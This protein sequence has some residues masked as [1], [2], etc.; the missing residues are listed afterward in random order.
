MVPHLTRRV[1]L[2]ALLCIMLLATLATASS[3]LKTTTGKVVSGTITGI[4]SSL[5]LDCSRHRHLDI[6]LS[7]V[8][9]IVVDFPR[10]IVETPTRVYIGPYSLFSGINEVIAIRNGQTNEEIPFASLRAIAPNG[11]AFH[12]L[13]R[14]WLEDGFVEY[15]AVLDIEPL[16]TRE[17]SSTTITSPERTYS[18]QTWEELYQPTPIPEEEEETPWWLL[19]LI[20]VGLGALVYFSL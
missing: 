11:H 3:Q 1:L 13:P 6:L 9:Q 17:S 20:A 19:L 16:I 18:A 14:N 4:A 5:R 7:D 8:M 15:P 10:V 2:I 12:E